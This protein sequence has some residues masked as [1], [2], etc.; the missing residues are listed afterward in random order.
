[1]SAKGVFELELMTISFGLKRAL[2][3][4]TE[5]DLIAHILD[6]YFDK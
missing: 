3:F 6:L 4:D 5:I 1:M 2:Y